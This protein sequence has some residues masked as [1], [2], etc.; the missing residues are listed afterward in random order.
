MID[1]GWRWRG[2]IEPFDF[3]QHQC[4]VGRLADRR[5]EKAHLVRGHQLCELEAAISQRVHQEVFDPVVD[6]LVTNLVAQIQFHLASEYCATPAAL[7]TLAR[8]SA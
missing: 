4:A 3:G 5:F 2:D 8:S 6:T 7:T 1:D